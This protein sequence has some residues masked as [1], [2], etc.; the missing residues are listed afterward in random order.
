MS[1]VAGTFDL[2]AVAVI[3]VVAVVFL[4]TRFVERRRPGASGKVVVG[5]SLQKGLERARRHR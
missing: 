4:V 1:A 5:A 3:V 2:V